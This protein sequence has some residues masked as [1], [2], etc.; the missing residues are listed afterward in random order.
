VRSISATVF[1]TLSRCFANSGLIQLLTSADNQSTRGKQAYGQQ[2][3]PQ[4][5]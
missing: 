2:G 1:L 5:P 3:K 4:Q